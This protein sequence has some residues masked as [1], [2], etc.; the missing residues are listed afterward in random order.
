MRFSFKARLTVSFLAVIAITGTV[1][2]IIGVHLIG[3]G[4]LREA[5][6]KVDLDLNTARRIYENRLTEIRSALEFTAMREFG[7]KKALQEGRRELLKRA[8]DAATGHAALDFMTVTDEKGVVVLRAQNPALS[9]DDKADDELVGRVISEKKPVT[10]TQILSR[11][12]LLEESEELAARARMELVPTPKAKPTE[13]TESTSGMVLKAAVP[14]L[15]DNGALVGVL[16]GGVLLNRN[17]EI[18]DQT[19]SIVYRGAR[20]E[21]RDIGTATIFQGDLRI[22]TN[23]K[24]DD[25]SRAIGTRLSGEVYD[26]VIGEGGVWKGRAF[27][28]NDWYLSAYEPIRDVRGGIVG[29]LYVGVLEKKYTDM[30]WRA[31]WLFMG[32]T[33]GGMALALVAAYL[34]AYAIARPILKVRDGVEAV[35]GGDFDAAVRVDSPDEIGDLAQAFNRL[36]VELKETY[37]KLHGRIEA[38]DED[39]KKAYNELKEKQEQLV[40]AEKLASLGSLAAG[41]AHEINNPLGTITLYAQMTLDDLPETDAEGRENLE[42]VLKHATRAAEIVKNLLAFARRSELKAGSVNM[43]AV[44]EEALSLTNHQA[45]LQNVRVTRELAEGLPEVRGDADKLRQVFVNM[46]INAL[47]AMPHEGRLKVRTSLSAGG[48]VVVVEISD[49]GCGIPEEVMPKLFDPFFTTKGTG[50]GTGLGLS[51]SHGMVKQHGGT[52]EVESEVGKG[53]TFTV[54]IPVSGKRPE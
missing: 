16:Y 14:V 15:G 41:V 8:L 20:Y 48:D 27:V 7:V 32:T 47:Q 2:G 19:K 35:A 34:L 21:G 25:G 46:I 6:N 42:I 45:E 22:S 53:T 51:V 11:K 33:V 50:K 54:G 49:T 23:V 13:R 5:Q 44:L 52:I 12:K 39:L 40:H 30:K 29:V 31:F 36:R 43:N 37:G 17:Y 26:R 10:G 3:S 4:V 24:Q 38:A 9:G 1:A 28:V 18:V